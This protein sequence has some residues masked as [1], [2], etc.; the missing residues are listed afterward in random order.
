MTVCWIP[1][2]KNGGLNFPTDW[3]VFIP[4]PIRTQR[5]FTLI[6]S[7]LSGL[8]DT[9]PVKSKQY[10]Y[11][12]DIHSNQSYRLTIEPI[13]KIVLRQ[14]SGILTTSFVILIILGFSFWFLIRTICGRK[15]WKRWRATLPTISPTSWKH[16]LPWR[17]PPTMLCLISIWQ[18]T[19]NNGISIWVSARNSYSD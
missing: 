13:Y 5:W 1:I 4:V 10:N 3:S 8:P 14:M 17:M 16:L 9:Y 12:F 7:L 19:S 2:C 18:K 6:R 11:A 15:H